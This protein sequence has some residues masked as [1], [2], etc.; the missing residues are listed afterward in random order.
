M[1][2]LILE[3]CSSG[4][5]ISLYLRNIYKFF[6]KKDWS[7]ILITSEEAT[8]SESF[9]VLKKEVGDNFLYHTIDFA[10]STN[11]SNLLNIFQH[12]IQ[13]WFKVRKCYKK[14]SQTDNFDFV[15]IPAADF[16]IHALTILRSPFDHTPFFTTLISSKNHLN[17]ERVENKLSSRI[18]KITYKYLISRFLS[19]KSLAKLFVIDPSIKPGLKKVKYKHLNKIEFLPDFA[20]SPIKFSKEK[21]RVALGLNNTDF[22]ILAY[23]SLSLRKGIIN[24]L[25]SIKDYDAIETIRV[26][27]AG[28]PDKE[29]LEEY[30]NLIEASPSLKKIIIQRLFYH[31][32]KEESVVFNSADCIWLGYTHGFSASS[33]VLFQSIAYGIPTI[34]S[35]EG[36]IGGFIKNYK[37][38]VLCNSC[39][40]EDIKRAIKNLQNQIKNKKY[41]NI[42]NSLKNL[43]I[44]H[45]P[46]QHMTE[47]ITQF[48]IYKM[49]NE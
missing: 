45:S 33:G 31:N 7:I 40:T 2:V 16:F 28:K 48:E 49:Y 19:T 14:L 44:K 1:K 41:H 21:A 23:G 5:H 43:S 39:D 27:I 6:K 15:Y 26:V 42:R 22:V 18:K 3:P 25:D 29:F 10:E 35:R 17:I 24:L 20:V 30:D 34:A 32:D 12:Q 36:L 8:K 11:S 4:H 38:G 13:W 9:K 37:N 46:K 47:L